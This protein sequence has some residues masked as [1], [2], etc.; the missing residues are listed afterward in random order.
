MI[1]NI[2]SLLENHPEI[3][4]VNGR[5]LEPAS[6]ERI[7]KAESVLGARLDP[8]IRQFFLDH[9]GLNVEWIF[10]GRSDYEAEAFLRKDEVMIL[11]ELLEDDYP[12]RDGQLIIMPIEDIFIED[13]DEEEGY[14]ASGTDEAWDIYLREGYGELKEGPFEFG[15]TTYSSEIEFRRRLRYIDFFQR[16]MAVALLLEPGNPDPPVLFEEVR[17]GSFD[18]SRQI[19]MSVYLQLVMRDFGLRWWRHRYFDASPGEFVPADPVAHLEDIIGI[20]RRQ[21]L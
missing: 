3:Q 4:L 20:C 8:V 5:V 2:V 16:D 19:P 11:P 17:G 9:N 10:K 1:Q 6:E 18:V 15:R 14:F 12:P 21:G 13:F 7:V